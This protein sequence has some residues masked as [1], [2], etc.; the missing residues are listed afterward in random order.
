MD[1][2]TSSGS[3]VTA[4]AVG[5]AVGKWAARR[6]FGGVHKSQFAALMGAVGSGGRIQRFV[7][8]VRGCKGFG[9]E[10]EGGRKSV[11][12]GGGDRVTGL[13]LIFDVGCSMPYFSVKK[14]GGGMMLIC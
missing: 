12:G 14:Y 6:P 5:N 8:S 7:L 1:L 4:A 11:H 3:P 13:T 10:Q 2:L 9:R